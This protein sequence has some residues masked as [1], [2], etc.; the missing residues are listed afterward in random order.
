[1]NRSTDFAALHRGARPGG[2][3]AT[4]LPHRQGQSPDTRLSTSSVSE[5]DA[6]S[7]WREIISKSFVPLTAEPVAKDGFRGNLRQATIGGLE[8]ST[9]VADGQRVRRTRSLIAHG[10]GEFLLASIQVQGEGKVEQ[11]GRATVLSPGEMV[12]Y[13]S[14]RPYALSFEQPMH[15]V[16]VRVPKQDVVFHDSRAFTARSLGRGTPGA[17]V[18]SFLLSFSET[19]M[20]DPGAASVLESHALGLLSAATSYAS[21]TAPPAVAVDAM[22]QEKVF[23]FLRKNLADSRLDAVIIAKACN[24]SRRT[25]YRLTGPIGIGGR[26]RQMRLERA[27]FLLQSGEDRPISAIAAACGFESE[28]GFYRAF[29]AA[30]GMTPVEYR[31]RQGTPGQ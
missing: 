29:R 7:L 20:V 3:R 11:D 23:D 26:L 22:A 4:Y 6:F 21:R 28:S 16:V 2:G 19:A 12:F 8:L 15:Q 5:R 30:T 14:A 10:S 24:V 25:L 31:N 27:R 9:V 13:D 18:A 1:M 17:A